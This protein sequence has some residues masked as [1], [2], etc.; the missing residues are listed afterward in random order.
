MTVS[1]QVAK[2]I[3][4]KTGWNTS[5][6]RLQKILYIAHML[7][8]GETETPLIDDSFEGLGLRS[9]CAKSLSSFQ[10]VWFF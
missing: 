5:N 9:S 1:I 8:I 10:N 7:H 6:L 4:E 2:Y 3:C